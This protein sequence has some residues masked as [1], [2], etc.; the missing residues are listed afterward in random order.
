MS[1]LM[2]TQQLMQAHDR[3]IQTVRAVTNCTEQQAD[4]FVT[5]VVALVFETLKQYLPGEDQ[6]N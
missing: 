6:C 5:A 4:E 1:D 3:A 2:L